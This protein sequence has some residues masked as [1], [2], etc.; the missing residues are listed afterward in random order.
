[1]DTAARLEDGRFAAEIASFLDSEL[2]EDLRAAGRR[3]SNTYSEIDAAREWHGKLY[4]RGWVAPMWPIAYGGAG[5]TQRQR[6][7]FEHECAR[8]D[9]PILFAGGIRNVG[10]LL[11]A[12]GTPEQRATFLPK[13]LSGEDL[14]CQ[15]F[16][17]TGAGSD[18][19]ALQLWARREDDT[20]ILSGSK[21]WTT[22]AH[23]ANRMFGLV[24]TAHCER[25][26]D[27]ITF[28]LIDMETPGLTVR[29]IISISGDHEIN[30]V[31]FDDV[32]VPAWR[33]VGAENEGWAVAK[34][35][36]RFARSSNTTSGLV[37]RAINA[38]SRI[39]GADA[40]E[41]LRCR[42]AMLECE[43]AGLEALEIRLLS[44]GGEVSETTSSM[45]KTIATELHQRVSE[46]LL[47]AVGLE[48]MNPDV[49]R[50]GG[51]AI[52]KYLNT[53]A[54]SIYSGTNETHR[55]LIGA[56]LIKGKAGYA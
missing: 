15:G 37:R 54:A 52:H 38:A 35:L 25:K 43:I 39:V 23:D 49:D 20:Y 17:E 2:T 12:A 1:M 9:A 45:L 7:M 41:G 13:I 40:D 22:G 33:R 48:A 55:N 16:S 36:M 27:G 19:A 8:Q 46:L 26:Q 21:I 42:A 53:R 14:W 6:L 18:L 29:P 32:R 28:L 51:M 44:V 3:T 24:R 50:R 4:R 10:P 30:Q 5:W 56:S 34:M 47:E 11:I 31:F